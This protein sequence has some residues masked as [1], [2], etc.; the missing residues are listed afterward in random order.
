MP[1]NWVQTIC[2]SSICTKLILSLRN[3]YLLL[4][5]LWQCPRF[6]S[7]FFPFLLAREQFGIRAP[8]SNSSETI[9]QLFLPKVNQNHYVGPSVTIRGPKN[10]GLLGKWIRNVV[11]WNGGKRSDAL[12]F[13]LMPIYSSQQAHAILFHAPAIHGINP[14]LAVKC[15]CCYCWI[16]TGLTVRKRKQFR[17]EL[18]SLENFQSTLFTFTWTVLRSMCATTSNGFGGRP[19]PSHENR[20]FSMILTQD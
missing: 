4:L 17:R 15:G 9:S 2:T 13:H 20:E 3:Y 7:L 14:I 18:N 11:E 8:K 1:L 16:W 10:P 12:K 19:A 6:R 5:H